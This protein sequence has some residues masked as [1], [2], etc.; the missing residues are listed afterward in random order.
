MSGS[1]A[2]PPASVANLGK[3]TGAA[4]I[5]IR[6]LAS[7]SISHP[8]G[9][10]DLSKVMSGN[11]THLR[12]GPAVER[13]RQKMHAQTGTAAVGGHGG[14][15]RFE[16]LRHDGDRRLPPGS[17]DVGVVNRP[18]SAA[19]S[20]AEADDGD[21]DLLGE[22]VELL[23]RS[24]ALLADAV[25]RDPRDDLRALLAEATRPLIYDPL[26]RPP[27]PVGPESDDPAGELAGV[28][29]GPGLVLRRR[30]GWVQH[31]DAAHLR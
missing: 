30:C 19:A 1:P 14:S 5:S 28:G 11:L 21:V 23:R 3:A 15:Q 13:I 24:L 9:P 22:V 8:E 10:Q 26:E 16:L 7:Q 18:G 2:P 29:S 27:R 25:A 20:I 6:S 31:C 4:A 17:H 12:F